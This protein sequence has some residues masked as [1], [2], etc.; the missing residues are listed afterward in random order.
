MNKLKIYKLG[1]KN[2]FY[3]LKIGF[4]IKDIKVGKFK[5]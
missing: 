2:L 1:K 4:A 3:K 5:N